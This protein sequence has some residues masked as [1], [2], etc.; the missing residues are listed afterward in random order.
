MPASAPT[1]PAPGV[2]PVPTPRQVSATDLRLV[3]GALVAWGVA[4]W[5]TSAGARTALV[6][7]AAAAGLLAL[8]GMLLLVRRARPPRGLG[9]CVLVA[10]CA[11]AVLLGGTADLVARERGGAAD[12]AGQGATVEV[13]GRVVQ[14]PVVV[15]NPWSGASD[16]VR[17]ALDLTTVEGRGVVAPGGGRIG[18]LGDLAWGEADYGAEVRASGR[19]LPAGPGDRTVATLVASGPPVVTAPPSRA[20]GVVGVLRADLLTASDGLPAD[21]RALLPGVAVG[22]TSRIDDELDAALRTTGLTHVTAVSGGHFAIVVATVTALCALARAPRGVRIGVTGAVMAGFVLLVH[23][24]PSVLRAAAMGVVGLVGIGLGRPSRAVPALAAVVVVLLVLDPSLARSYGFV[25]SSVATAALVLGTQPVARRLA[26][27][28]GK[29]PAFALAVPLTAQ[30]AC[31]P[32]LVLLDPSI[33]T[34]AVPANLVAAPALVPATVLGVLATLVAPWFPLG[35]VVLAW[36]AGL[37]SWWIAAVARFFTGLPGARVPWPGGALGAVALALLT[38]AALVLVWR[39]R[40]V[41]GLLGVR[42]PWSRGSGWP[43]TWRTA[44]RAGVREALAARRRRATLRLVAAWAVVAVAAV[45]CVVIAWPRWIAPAGRDVPA[46]WAVAA[47]DVGQGDGLVVR[48]GDGRGLMI[49]VGPAGDAA[50]RCLDDLGIERLDLLV[51]THFHADHV[52]GLG[53]VLDGRQ[54]GRALV[55][56]LGDP[57]EQAE[58]VLDDLADRG[59]PVEVAEPGAGGTLGDVSWE[60]LQ[61]GSTPGPGASGDGR[62]RLAEADG[63]ANDAS[64]AL[65]VV[66]PRLTLVALGD[67]EAGGQETLDRTLR[68]RAGVPSVDVVKVAHHGSRVQSARL[69]ATLSP[70]VAI[71]SSGEN[72]YGHP[73]QEA[74]DL[75]AGVGAAVLRTDRCG[76]FALVVRDGALAVAGCEDG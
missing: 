29:G 27:W 32:V 67:L 26:P 18:V 64:I 11:L 41:A 15:V 52:G 3:P 76:T 69:A 7:A 48:T 1:I 10:A 56:G 19:L 38:L 24:D 6:G 16:S 74:L 25:L 68:A 22:D 5:L 37:A 66:T 73:T 61:A 75:Y 2:A 57:A 20:L 8:M 55:T 50:G 59:V 43:H 13:V 34:Y 35:G 12:L 9:Q 36:P 30:L 21:A 14:E 44:V 28:I 4:W 60:V 51:L 65:R 71:V 42:V 47:C 39:W 23:P 17:T 53:A 72:T 54:V 62:P 31:A 58:W 70:A 45:G 33:A 40:H 63:G 49:D 46:D